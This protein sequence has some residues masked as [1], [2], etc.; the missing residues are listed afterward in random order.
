VAGGANRLIAEHRAD[1]SRDRCRFGAASV[2]GPAPSAA[3]WPALKKWS[4]PI[5]MQDAASR[6][7]VA[8][9]R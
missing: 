4:R 8:D 6:S 5:G 9:D 2:T 1:R 3:T 7:R